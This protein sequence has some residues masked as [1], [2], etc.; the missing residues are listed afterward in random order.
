MTAKQTER[1]LTKEIAEVLEL[2]YREANT[3]YH[4][5]V[6]A[7]IKGFHTREKLSLDGIGGLKQFYCQ[8]RMYYTD[9]N[10]RMY[11]PRYHEDK[12]WK[13]GRW[14]A[15]FKP[16]DYMLRILNSEA[17]EGTDTLED[18]YQDYRYG[19]GGQRCE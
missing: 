6:D 8:P 16:S 14:K 17:Y 10:S 2:S 13:P 3:I 7:L 5:L 11:D 1:Y 4:A 15:T 9:H 18:L 12:V 19:A